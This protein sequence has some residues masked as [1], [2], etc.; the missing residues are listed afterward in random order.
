MHTPNTVN[1]N[2]NTIN[3]PAV[4]VVSFSTLLQTAASPHPPISTLPITTIPIPILF[5][6]LSILHPTNPPNPVAT[7]CKT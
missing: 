7:Q 5:T 6:I 3:V 2:I 4:V 1:T